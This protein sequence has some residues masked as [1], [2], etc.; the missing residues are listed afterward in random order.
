MSDK[1]STSRSRPT[2][3]GR[4]ETENER[5]DRNWNEMLQEL[6]VT[7]TGTQILTG[8]LLTLA[9][10]P[11]FADLD[12]F[13]VAV[14]LVLVGLAALSTALGLGPVSLHRALFRKRK[15]DAVVKIADRLMMGILLCV[16]LLVT[17]VVLL[18]FDFV[19]GRAVGVVAGIV[20]AILVV[21]VWIALPFSHRPRGGGD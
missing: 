15:K 6:R 9:F 5:L 17:G 14:Y 13:Q 2:D 10:Q 21:L 12:D 19:L 11:R 16:G 8:F 20:T 1:A 7:Q 18:I 4:N 3:S